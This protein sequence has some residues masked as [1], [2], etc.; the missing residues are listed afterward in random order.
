VTSA[1]RASPEGGTSAAPT[2]R[3]GLAANWPQ[4]ALLVLVNAF[5]GGMVGLERTT[6]SL[7]GARVFHLSGYLAVF[8]FIVAFGV[9]KAITNLAAGPLTTRHTRKTLLVAG[10]VAGVPVPFLLAWAPAWW[11]IVAANVLLG[12][13]QGLAW[14][15]TV[16]MKIDLVGPRGRGLA[17]GFN[18][19]AG[20][21]AVGGTALATGYLAAAYGLRPVPELIGVVYVG[22]GLAL[23]VLAVRDTAAHV[24]AEAARH[25]GGGQAVARRPFGAVFAEV[26]WRNLSLRGASQ[27]GLVNNLNDGL[28]WGVFPLLFASRGLGLAAI[29]LI[30][31]LY[32]LLWGAGQLVTGRLSDTIGRKPLIVA[33]MIVQAAAFPAALMLPGR[34]LAAGVGSAVLLGAGTAMVYPALIASVAD[35]THPAW[36]AQ[37]LGVYRFWR[38]LGYAVGAVIAGLLAGAFGLST[39][40]LAGGALTLAS[41]LLAARWIKA[42]RPGP[43]APAAGARDDAGQA[44]GG[45]RGLWRR[46]AIARSLGRRLAIA[47]SSMP[48]HRR[49]WPPRPWAR[50]TRCPAAWRRRSACPRTSSSCRTAPTGRT[51]STPGPTTRPTST[52]SGCWPRWRAPGARA[53]C[54]PPGWPRPPRCS[55]PCFPVITCWSPGSCTGG[56]ASGSPNSPSPGAWTWSSPTPAIWPRSRRRSARAAPGCCG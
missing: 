35:H 10:W 7:V 32:P 40:V 15:M 27:A 11:W 24:A 46:R 18:E 6:T 44:E 29:G 56:C 37:G 8:S 4:F 54:S 17:M 41:G 55:S 20:Y 16:N 36:R 52:P 3:L 50:W 12:V 45:T 13:N 33:G 19:A 42:S 5:V 30:K 49:R 9:T 22:A 26:S 47:R 25:P 21:L 2:V 23:S 53:R 38:D 48:C 34:P 1:A 31:G 39:T 43:G 51:G 14:S 28:T